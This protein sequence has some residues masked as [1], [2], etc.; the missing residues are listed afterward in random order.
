M[1]QRSQEWEDCRKAATNPYKVGKLFNNLETL[2]KKVE[3][4]NGKS[5]AGNHVAIIDE[6]RNS[7]MKAMT[8]SREKKLNSVARRRLA[9]TF[10]LLSLSRRADFKSSFTFFVATLEAYEPA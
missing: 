6:T 3:S 9:P 7:Y 5:L 4:L 8:M 10:A 2:R 1:T